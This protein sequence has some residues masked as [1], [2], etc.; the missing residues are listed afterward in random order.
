M[1]TR[2]TH[3]ENGLRDARRVFEPRAGRSLSDED[4]R[5]IQ[6]NLVGFF[7]VLGEWAREVEG[8]EEGPKS[9]DAMPA[10]KTSDR[11]WQG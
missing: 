11:A 5:E 6:V 10:S 2:K 1:A 8:S 4:L 3:H 7:R 9:T